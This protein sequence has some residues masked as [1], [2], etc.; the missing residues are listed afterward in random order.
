MPN[1]LARYVM[2]PNAS[3]DPVERTRPHGAVEPTPE[4]VA[5]PVF[6]YRGQET[7]GV[8]TTRDATQV[9]PNTWVDA[10]DYEP[11]YEALESEPEPIPVRIVVGDQ[12]VEIR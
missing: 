6:A 1:P 4:R 5:G 12:A 11:D 10:A 3:V 9:D 8:E 2:P 7:H